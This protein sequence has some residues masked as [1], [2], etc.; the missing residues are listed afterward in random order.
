MGSTSA[1]RHFLYLVLLATLTCAAYSNSLQVP[2]TFDDF[3]NIINKKSIR[4]FTPDLPGII[5]AASEGQSGTRWLPNLTLTLNYYF[6]GEDVRGYHLVNLGI[7]LACALVFYLLCL[8]TLRLPAVSR[9]AGDRTVEIAMAAALLWAVHPLQ[10]NAVTYLVQRMTSICALFYLAALLCYVQGRL[11]TGAVL[12]QTHLFAASLLFGLL[13]VTSKEN[14]L[15]LP[16]M[17]LAYDFFFLKPHHWV[18]ENWVKILSWAGATLAFI[19]LLTIAFQGKEIFSIILKGYDY[20]NFTLTERLLTETRV[21]FLY[22]SLL[23]FPS[24]ARLNLNHEFVL[25]R[26][27]FSPP[28]TALALLGILLLLGLVIGSFNRNRLFSFA[29]FWFLGNL[30]IES[31]V[32]PL[33]L[34]FEHRLYLPATFLF[35]SGTTLLFTLFR[36]GP[37]LARATCLLLACLLAFWTWQRNQAWATSIT[38]WSDVVAKSP[39]LARGYN[40]LGVAYHEARDFKTAQFLF[41]KAIRIEPESRTAYISLGSMYVTQD[42][43]TE[44]EKILRTALT[45][46]SYLSPSRIYHYLGVVYRKAGNYPA[47]IEYS[48]RALHLEKNDLTPLINLGI[49]YEKLGD[50]RKADNTFAEALSAGLN[51]SV[52]LYNNWGIAVFKMGQTDRAI[53][54][55]RQGLRIDPNHPETHYNLGLAYGQKGMTR[56][57]QEEMQRAMRLQQ[58]QD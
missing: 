55:F 44:A 22:L 7:H 15:M 48:R 11:R 3:A 51:D 23:A 54:Y 50:Y 34:V 8:T 9:M 31:T 39:G 35:L 32:V 47:A 58:Q 30:V 16:A 33:E 46:E 38:L 56:E 26:S 41:E 49:V 13:A 18:N 36:P 28:Q 17:V 52:D 42:R 2:F 21:I 27:L 6:G 29:L 1:L 12:Q 24:P 25:S 19:A 57:A 43:L 45:K 14:A 37:W 20:R 40:N 10:T 53:E 4:M 5:S